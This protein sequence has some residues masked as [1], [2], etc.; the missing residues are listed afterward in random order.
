VSGS[1]SRS[2]FII[3]GRSPSSSDTQVLLGVDLRQAV[4]CAAQRIGL[5]VQALVAHE[6][7]RASA[8]EIDFEEWIA[9]DSAPGSSDGR[10]LLLGERYLASIV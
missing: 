8:N 4:V 1:D 7:T 6:W 2:F 10:T 5:D 3:D 9:D